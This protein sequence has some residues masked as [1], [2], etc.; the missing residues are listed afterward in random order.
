MTLPKGWASAVVQDL[1]E[2]LNG[3]AFKPSDWSDDGIGII[4][5]QNLTDRTKP[6][7]RTRR[8]F[9]E[10]YRVRRGEILVSWS[11]TLDAFIWDGDDAVLNQHI[12]KVSPSECVQPRFL[13]YLLREL[14]AE[15]FQSEH[16]HGSTMKHINRG[17]FLAHKAPLPPLAEQRRIV[18]KLDAL[19]ARLARAQGEAERALVLAKRLKARALDRAFVERGARYVSEDVVV[20]AGIDARTGPWLE[21][22]NGYVWKSFGSIGKVSG[23]LTKNAGRS[24]SFANV[25][26]LRVAN[27]Y[28]NELRLDDVAEI[29]CTAKEAERT[30]LQA[31]DVL[32]VE[33]NGSLQQVGRAAMWNDEIPGCSHQNHI[34]RMR[35]SMDVLPK[36]AVFWLMSTN[37]RASIERLAASSSGLHTLSISK[38]AGLP[39]PVPNLAEQYRV[40]A[41]IERTFA[42]ADRLETEARKALALIERLEAAILAKAF[43][44]ELVPQDPNDEPASVLL[45]RIRAR[46]AA[47][48]KVNRGR[49]PKATE[50]LNA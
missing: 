7:N 9:D 34:I 49:R 26:Y 31:G 45:E 16:L 13:F 23:G 18:T 39:I 48:P 8:A 36:F 47:E 44:G 30:R 33:G 35:P 19:T 27:V 22:K 14:I 40:V 3:M 4:R 29:A 24:G 20:A 21:A 32:I 15:L 46:R 50:T 41:R 2:F 43:R 6:L 1:G 5:I 25:P 11:A 42:R 38:V 10:R 17:P 28:S 12:F 37:G